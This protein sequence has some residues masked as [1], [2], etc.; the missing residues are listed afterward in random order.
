[1]RARELF[2]MQCHVFII[3]SSFGIKILVKR[4]ERN[5]VLLLAAVSVLHTCRA[6][7]QG[8]QDQYLQQ[9]A[10]PLHSAELDGDFGEAEL[11]ALLKNL[12]TEYFPRALQDGV[13]FTPECVNS[14]LAVYM[15]KST[16]KANFTIPGP[17]FDTIV[18]ATGKQGPGLLTGN[19]NLDGAYDECFSINDTGFCLASK[20][21]L[22]VKNPLPARLKWT[23]G[24]CVPKY[25]TPQ[26]MSLLVNSTGVL[27]VYEGD[28]ACANTR[29]P[30][31]G[32]GA[33]VM[34]C[35]C[36]VFVV[37]VV[38]G[39]IV[40][41]AVENAKKFRRE[42]WTGNNG[43]A[44]PLSL[45][46]DSPATE[47]SLLL[48]NNNTP[49]AT[50]KKSV[51]P[52]DIITAFSL[53]KTVPALLATKQAP[54]VI[55]SLNGLRVISMFW[56]IL[57]HTHFW[58]FT[59]NSVKIDNFPAL[60]TT[61]GRFSFQGVTAGFFAVDTFFVLS[62]V[63]VAYLTLRQ[64][65]RAKG[66]F[67]VVSFY[68]HRFLRITPTYAFVLFFAWFL[69][70]HFSYGPNLTLDPPFAAA[71]RKYWWTNLLYINNLYPWGL[72]EGCVG[73]TWYLANDMQFYI[74]S[75]LIII[76]TYYLLPVKRN[77]MFWA[78]GLVAAVSALV[79]SG[80]IVT[81]TL[82]SI[83]D[84]QA[85]TFSLLAYN[86]TGDSTGTMT[87]ANAIYIKPWDR[88][89]TY[90][91]GLVLGYVLFKGFKFG[92]LN[93][94]TRLL[95]YMGVWCVTAVAMFWL[96][97][98]LYFTWHGHIPGRFENFVYITLSRPI[99]GLAVAA[100]VFACHNG[101]G[102][103]VDSFLS[104]K[105]WIPLSRLTFNAYLVHPIVLT[106]IYGQL[107]TVV[108]YTD[109]TMAV[110]LVAFV[111]FSYATAAVV[112]VVVE[113]PL[114]TIEMMLFKLVGSVR[115]SGGTPK[116]VNLSNSIN[117]GH[118]HKEINA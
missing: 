63:L 43:E 101:Y 36:A 4:M 34:L 16:P 17:H 3:V 2:I 15:Y 18:D 81:G 66:R 1:M 23:V 73:W 98:G 111:V 58:I 109:V 45:N 104:M 40:D 5:L 110:Y 52:V 69:T 21:G 77:R 99:W 28:V 54:G 24:F 93:R 35:V 116:H 37:L 10:A 105:V 27:G 33:M 95:V 65:Q 46:N 48:N 103:V 67:P 91:V 57:G 26:D 7:G 112:C 59:T 29:T 20:I 39:S 117:G 102:W 50:T 47:K 32:A 82:T 31:Y 25:C 71:C 22:T 89:S 97:Y 83:Y 115:G 84:F 75:P 107:Q 51:S 70:V 68:V 94:L 86:S 44:I 114:S 79:I 6:Y 74:I 41:C 30:S 8:L 56:V 90:V 96:S 13:T 19:V 88:I 11:G 106:V 60:V 53:F 78:A 92:G 72:N 12:W 42:D 87:Y 80:I 85:N 49:K 38:S 113:F 108:H 9:E 14:T 61:A 62:G 55:T 100:V 64:M 118:Q 76:P